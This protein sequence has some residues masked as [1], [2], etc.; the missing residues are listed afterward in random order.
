MVIQNKLYART[1]IRV[2]VSQWAKI[3]TIFPDWWISLKSGN[4]L[5]A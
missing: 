4:Y 2:R 5:T 1:R 3:P